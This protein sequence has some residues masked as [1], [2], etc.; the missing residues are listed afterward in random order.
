MARSSFP[1]SQS[2]HEQGSLPLCEYLIFP[3]NSGYA[4]QVLTGNVHMH[5]QMC[6]ATITK[7]IIHF[8]F[9]VLKKEEAC[10]CLGADRVIRAQ[11]TFCVHLEENDSLA[12]FIIFQLNNHT[13]QACC[14][15][16]VGGVNR[17]VTQ[18]VIEY[19]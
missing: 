10:I 8:L 16:S 17:C 2:S 12:V 18:C 3:G 1:V 4:E 7:Y 15:A 9:F 19:H 11:I 13:K 14:A 5:M 6:E